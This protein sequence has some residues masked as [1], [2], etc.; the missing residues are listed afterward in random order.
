M[1]ATRARL[2]ETRTTSVRFASLLHIVTTTLLEVD[3]REHS[4][5]HQYDLLS[6]LQRRND[7]IA[8]ATTD[9]DF[10]LGQLSKG[11]GTIYIYLAICS[12]LVFSRLVELS[13]RTLPRTRLPRPSEVVFSCLC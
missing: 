1:E 12:Y 3:R 7:L 10:A 5:L 13:G 4:R 2:L 8:H 11:E 9:V 6:P